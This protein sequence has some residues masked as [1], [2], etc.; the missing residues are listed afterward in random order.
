MITIGIPA[1]PLPAALLLTFAFLLAG[2]WLPLTRGR[3]HQVANYTVGVTI[4]GV[5]LTWFQLTNPWAAWHFWLF[6]LVG[7]LGVAGAYVVDWVV[8]RL[9]REASERLQ[10]RLHAEPR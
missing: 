7:G 6:F 3:L 2:H 10:E 5:F 8:A 4:V 1:L 9:E